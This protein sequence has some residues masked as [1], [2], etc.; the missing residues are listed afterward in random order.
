MSGILIR[1]YIRLQQHRPDRK[2]AIHSLLMPGDV[3]GETALHRKGFSLQTATAVI[4]CHFDPQEFE[5]LLQRSRD[6][7]RAVY[8]LQ[9]IKLDQLDQLGLMTWI[10]GASGAQERLCAFLALATGFMPYFSASPTSGVLTLDLPR[11]DIA[12]LS[13]TTVESISLT[14]NRLFK[15]GIL[16]VAGPR[17]PANLDLPRLIEPGCLQDT[18]DLIEWPRTL[19]A[20]Q[21]N[22]SATSAS[23]HEAAGIFRLCGVES[24]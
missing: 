10:L 15:L 24:L 12:G 9:T 2:L 7:T 1:G 16:T 6:L 17:G 23:S 21:E 18:F 19:A 13:H 11:T 5:D 14:S 20:R 3:V 4:L 8:I 22:C